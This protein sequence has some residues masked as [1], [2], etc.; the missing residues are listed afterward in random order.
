MRIGVAKCRD[1]SV[2]LLV[3]LH[4]AVPVHVEHQVAKD[5]EEIL[6]DEVCKIEE[7]ASSA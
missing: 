4:E 5:K 1:S 2:M 6:L 7:H 3:E